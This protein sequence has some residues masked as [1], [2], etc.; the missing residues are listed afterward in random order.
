MLKNK[1]R[2]HTHHIQIRHV[3]K[4]DSDSIFDCDQSLSIRN[5]TIK[6]VSV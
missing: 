4:K 3:E 2:S 1:K 5:D 6:N